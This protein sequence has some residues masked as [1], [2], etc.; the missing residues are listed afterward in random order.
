MRCVFILPKLIYNVFMIAYLKGK[1]I[2]KGENYVVLENNGVGYKVFT[3]PKILEMP[4][5]T[6]LEL[7]TYLQVREDAQVLFGFSNPAD[8]QFFELLITVSGVGPKLAL[9]ILS[10]ENT[11]LVKQAIS[12]QD[13]AIFTRIGGIGKKTAEKIIL[14]LKEKMGALQLD[15]GAAKNSGDVINALENLGYSNKEIKEVLAKLDHS[16]SSE[17]KL[18]QA[19]KILGR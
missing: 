19:L 14:E 4:I 18:R 16:L 7:Y 2:S 17:E 13:S 1:I 15:K 12:T 3:T 9:S 8:L 5:A 11:E 6:E 10:A